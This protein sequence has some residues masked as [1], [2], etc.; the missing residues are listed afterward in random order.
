MMVHIPHVLDE[1]EVTR[2]L[3]VMR[4]GSWIDGRVTAG[5][6]SQKVKNNLQLPEGS[7]EHRELGKLI[8]QALL[9]N[10]LFVSAVLPHTIFPPLFNR[11]DE[12]MGFGTHVDSAVRL[13]AE[14][15]LRIRT[16]VSATLFLTGPEDYDGGE[17]TVEDTYGSH[18]VKLPAGDLIVYPADS[19]HYVSPVTRGSRIASFFWIQSLI[20]ET[21]RRS[22][23]FNMDTAIISL[24][25]VA[26][27]HPALVSLQS[28]YHN[29]LRQWAEV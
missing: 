3:A 18:A 26:K 21:A 13:T 14:G 2:C 10:P 27:N 25:G 17:L 8:V 11:Y 9:R 22:L 29:L 6:Q 19:L 7:A 4:E 24:T 28:A 5:H 1:E 23:L 16:D 12:G 20:R 15:G